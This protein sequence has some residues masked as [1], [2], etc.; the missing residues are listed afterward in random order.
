M[1]LVDN[2]F[3]IHASSNDNNNYSNIMEYFPILRHQQNW[4]LP[5]I[6]NTFPTLTVWYM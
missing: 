4:D 6:S 1:D 5:P 2:R 3:P